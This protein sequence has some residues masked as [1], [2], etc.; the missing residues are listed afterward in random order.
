MLKI[1]LVRHGEAEGNAQRRFLGVTDAPLTIRGVEQ[2]K[3]TAARLGEFDHVYS[4]PLQR[5]YRTAELI[6]DGR[7][8]KEIFIMDE[9]KE[10]N[11]GIFD[12]LTIEEMEGLNLSARRAWT[13]DLIGFRIPD[14]ESM[15][16]LHFR[17]AGVIRQIL[18][19]H[20]AAIRGNCDETILIVSHLNTLR[21]I[22][23]SLL[24]ISVTDGQKFFISNA[25]I[26]RLNVSEERT[27]LVLT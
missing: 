10:R 19:R 22:L 15:E 12:N 6:T 26:V 7:Y 24:K 16:D 8:Q 14:G 1:T 27:E 18:R 13:G 17:A 25:G 23:V 2:V 9:L 11:F 4:S 5:A 21:M 20:D 3:C